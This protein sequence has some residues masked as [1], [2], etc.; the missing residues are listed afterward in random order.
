MLF[1]GQNRSDVS[2]RTGSPD[3]ERGVVEAVGGRGQVA[4][5]SVEVLD[6]EA[7][8]SE[9]EGVEDR[10]GGASQHHLDL[11]EKL[12]RTSER[13]REEKAGI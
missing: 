13:R 8:A 9:V 4:G 3:A 7:V 1:I 6:A 5:N 11:T 2:V 10:R 12:R